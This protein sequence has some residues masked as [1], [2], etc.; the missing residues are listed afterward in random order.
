MTTSPD[1]PTLS[2]RR[3]NR[4]LLA[5]QH[6]L[7][8]SSAPLPRVLER[9]GGLQDQYAPSGYLGLWSRMEGLERDRLTRALERRSVI[10]ATLL[11]GTIHL[12]SRR[13]FWPIA[14]AIRA[15]R[16][17]WWLRVQRTGMTPASMRAVAAR[18]RRL[19]ANGPRTRAEILA[20]LGLD[21]TT[22]NGAA[23][24]IDLVRV[25]PSGTW[26]RRRADLYGLAEDWV[27]PPD[28][29][30]ADGLAL[31]V[32]RYLTGF[33]PARP[34]DIAS[35]AGVAN[36]TLGPALTSVR[37]RRFR[38]EAGAELV[39]LPGAPLPDADTPA[40]AR[41]LPTWDATLLAHARRTQILPEL[42]RPRVFDVKTPHS[43]PTFLIDGRVAG[44]W[45]H[46]GG[47]IRIA[48]FARLPKA[49]ARELR[50]EADRLLDF[51]S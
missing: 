35:W 30:E 48:P 42:H 3:L 37:L 38:D 44:T 8:R 41:F 36:A 11:R 51:V 28:A 21:S 23:G 19:L 45:R 49:A 18:I 39:D 31:L 33:G 5:R 32:R 16:R 46:E 6:L 10:Q 34:A 7:D 14:T 25:P 22:W 40:P 24:W 43:V 1:L 50:E 15:D 17:T 4:A 29:T 9:M 13:D 27:G 12:V 26:D 47:R 2:E 20:E